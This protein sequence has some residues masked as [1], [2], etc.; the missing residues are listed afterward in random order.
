MSAAVSSNPMGYTGPIR[1]AKLSAGVTQIMTRFAHNMW[2]VPK[3]MGLRM[4][5]GNPV[6][7]G[8]EGGKLLADEWKG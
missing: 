4:R 3:K 7:P 1:S 8:G 6:Y 2:K 5:I